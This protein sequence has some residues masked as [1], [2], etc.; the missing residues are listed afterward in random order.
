MYDASMKPYTY[1]VHFEGAPGTDPTVEIY[2][3]G[4]LSAAILAKA[5][6]IQDGKTHKV[7]S[8]ECPET[9]TAWNN[10]NEFEWN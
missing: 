2:T 4:A 5:H 3:V 8:V 10:I 9:G 6:R 7:L 1:I